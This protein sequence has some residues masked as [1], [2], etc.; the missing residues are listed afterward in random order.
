MRVIAK[1]TLREFWEKYPDAQ[2]SLVFWYDKILKENWSNPNTIIESFRGADTVGNGRIVFNVAKNKY[3]LV[4][5]FVYETQICYVRF[6]GTHQEYDRIRD[7]QT[8]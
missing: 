2:A 7:I 5:K 3:R 4:V 8:I 6:V 1:S